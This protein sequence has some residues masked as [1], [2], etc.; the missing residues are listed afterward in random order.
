MFYHNA[1]V[2]EFFIKPAARRPQINNNSQFNLVYD[3][4]MVSTAGQ[5]GQKSVSH[6]V[7]QL[8][9]SYCR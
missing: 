2:C 1:C 6:F 5:S 3:W 8:A 7:I 4:N 9:F